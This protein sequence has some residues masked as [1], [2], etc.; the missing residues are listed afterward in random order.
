MVRARVSFT[1]INLTGKSCPR[2]CGQYLQQN[3]LCGL[4][5]S[6]RNTRKRTPTS[7]SSTTGDPRKAYVRFV[8][9]SAYS[10][11][12]VGEM[13]NLPWSQIIDCSRNQSMH[14]CLYFGGS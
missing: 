4:S 10:C 2:I 8:F 9:G 14:V 11:F 5:F 12:N 3:A 13:F 1:D 7:P 6:R